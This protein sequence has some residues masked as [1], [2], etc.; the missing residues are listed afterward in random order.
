MPRTFTDD[1]KELLE[2]TLD[3]YKGE[4]PIS[5]GALNTTMTGA[6]ATG[7]S[8]VAAGV[9]TIFAATN[10]ARASVVIA[11]LAVVAVSVAAQ[12]LI[13]RS[14]HQSRAAVTNEVIRSVPKLITVAHA[15]EGPLAAG[16]TTGQTDA[17]V[18]S[19]V[20]VP[21]N[22]AVAAGDGQTIPADFEVVFT[23]DGGPS[24]VIAVRTGAKQEMCVLRPG[25]SRFEWVAEDQ[26]EMTAA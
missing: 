12:A 9:G 3:D 26:A 24:K 14:D 5:A 4:G 8:A 23:G 16:A 15:S 18:R 1:A 22:G 13:I 7:F 21:V 11:I 19:A 17:G 10:G 2:K 25:A 6:I 20:L